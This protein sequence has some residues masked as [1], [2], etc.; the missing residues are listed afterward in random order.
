[1]K[2][3]LIKI[4]EKLKNIFLKMRLFPFYLRLPY[5]SN[6]VEVQL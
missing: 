5:L 3:F 6:Y 4:K 1:M 2:S